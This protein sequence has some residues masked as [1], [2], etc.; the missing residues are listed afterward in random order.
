MLIVQRTGLKFLAERIECGPLLFERRLHAR[1]GLVVY[2]RRWRQRRYAFYL[3]QP[4]T[5]KQ[6]D[7]Y[8]NSLPTAR[9]SYAHQSNNRQIRSA[10]LLSE[11]KSYAMRTQDGAA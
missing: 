8:Q 6:H 10:T 2:T 4:S 5:A 3:R 9:T 11:F 7:E 1:R